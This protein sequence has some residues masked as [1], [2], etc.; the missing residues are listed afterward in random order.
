MVRATW[1]I[2]MTCAYY[3]AISEAK[4]KKRQATDPNL[5]KWDS[6]IHFTFHY[7]FCKWLL[8]APSVHPSEPCTEKVRVR[9]GATPSAERG[10]SPVHQSRNPGS[11][12]RYSNI[13]CV[14]LLFTTTVIGMLVQAAVSSRQTQCSLLTGL[15][16]LQLSPSPTTHPV[17]AKPQSDPIVS[18]LR[19]F[20]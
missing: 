11:I 19:T 12:S 16:P 17:I 13:C 20:Q 3:S 10:A 18:L 1:L 9:P 4:I 5:G 6:T 14:R 8:P 2:K 15:C 7:W